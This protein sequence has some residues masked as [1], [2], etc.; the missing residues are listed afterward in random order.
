MSSWLFE[1]VYKLTSRFTLNKH[2][3]KLYIVRWQYIH[4]YI[5]YAGL[6]WQLCVLLVCPFSVISVFHSVRS[7]FFSFTLPIIKNVHLPLLTLVWS[8][9]PHNFM[10]ELYIMQDV[11][12]FTQG[13]YTF[14]HVHP[15]MWRAVWIL[16]VVS[17]CSVVY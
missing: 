10:L 8:S 5:L 13:F 9:Y 16:F 4:I 14:C 17:W 3:V 6:W 11:G 2:L 15:F 12:T 7:F 1:K